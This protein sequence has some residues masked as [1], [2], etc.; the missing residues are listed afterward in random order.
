MSASEHTESPPQ[1]RIW[2]SLL[3]VH[4]VALLAIG[5]WIAHQLKPVDMQALHLGDGERLKCVSYAPFRLPGQTPFDPDLRISREQ[6]LVDLTE[7]ARITECVRIYS[8]GQGLEQVPEI[9]GALGLKVL[10]GAWIS[11]D[12]KLSKVE[13]DHTIDLANRHP[14]TVAALIV[15]NEVLLRRERTAGQM[16]EL[17]MYTQARTAIPVSYADVWEFWI[18][19]KSLASVVDRVTVHILPFWED[20]P[21]AVDRAVAH[22]ATVLDEVRQHFDKP[23]LI[24]ETGWPSA[25]RQRAASLPS[26][27]NQARYIREFVRRAHDEGWDYNLIEAI[28]QP[29]KRRLEGTVGGHWGILDSTLTPKFPLAGAVAERNSDSLPVLETLAGAVLCLLLAATGGTPRPGRLRLAAAATTGAFGALVAALHIEHARLAYRDVP[30]W[31]VLGMVALLAALA[32]LLLAR[33]NATD[34]IPSAAAAWQTLRTRASARYSSNACALGLIRG[35]LLFAAAVAVVL[36]FTDPRYRDFPTLLY[37]V[38]ALVFGVTGWSSASRHAT[39]ER[40]CACLLAL[41]TIARWLA[42]PANP[43]AIAWLLTGLILAAPF[44][45]RHAREH[46]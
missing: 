21:V 45:R 25:G 14:T 37:L 9:A 11:S 19:N 22:V 38:P 42:E 23:V 24:G 30:E 28:D 5:A 44:L 31:S 6:I 43:Q 33:W 39:E 15:G 26:R 16:R 17:I 1:A 4:L 3:L 32:P 7:L 46:Q 36:L 20:D 10:L 12:A 35:V 18:R 13:L 41:A 2:L 8:V 27:V 40:L 34:P 29:W